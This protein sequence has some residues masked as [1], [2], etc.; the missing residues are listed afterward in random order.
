MGP[1][2][3]HRHL[4]GA[5]ADGTLS[6]FVTKMRLRGISYLAMTKL[7]HVQ[8]LAARMVPPICQRI[9]VLATAL[10]PPIEIGGGRSSHP[11]GTANDQSHRRPTNSRT[12][13]GQ[14]RSGSD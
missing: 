2:G 7:Q 10:V 3:R 1:S 14:S 13:D 8:R 5:G 4:F 6:G 12:S 9:A 11:A